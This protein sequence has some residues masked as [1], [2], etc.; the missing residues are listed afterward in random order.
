MMTSDRLMSSPLLRE[1]YEIADEAHRGQVRK[2]EESRP[3]IDHPVAVATILDEAGFD[4]EV[5]SAALLHDVVEDSEASIE[6]V[7]KR[8]GDRVA[9]LVSALTEDTTI[10]PYERR[11][12]ALR[13]SVEAAGRDA[14]AIYGAD[15]LSNIRDLRAGYAERGEDVGVEFST[16]LDGRIGLWEGDI[17]MLSEIEPPLGF[18]GELEHE[19]GRL[20]ADRSLSIRPS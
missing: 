6:G 15:K 12:E 11:K 13:D 2:G 1:A 18:V 4:D 9:K 8:F 14:A 7:R 20:L 19:L 10:E 5:L 16:S 3:Y 17:A